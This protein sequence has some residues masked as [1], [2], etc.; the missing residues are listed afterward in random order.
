MM[1]T[2]GLKQRATGSKLVNS[3]MVSPSG[4]LDNPPHYDCEYQ[5]KRVVSWSLNI[6]SQFLSC[7]GMV[8]A[9]LPSDTQHMHL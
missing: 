5:K 4:Q 1:I 7:F 6:N 9:E 2:E 3:R 8:M